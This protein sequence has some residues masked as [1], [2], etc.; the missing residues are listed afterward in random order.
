MIFLLLFLTP[1]L[2]IFLLAV[3]LPVALHPFN[4]SDQPDF[5]NIAEPSVDSIDTEILKERQT[6]SK[7][8]VV[9]QIQEAFWQARLG[10]A[11][12]D[13]I[14][15]SVDLIDSLINLE[16]KGVPMRLCKIQRYRSSGL[17]DRLR[18]QG[19]LRD[20]LSTPFILQKEL[21]TIP[22]API[23]IK[24][25]PKDTIEA[26]ESTGE[27]LKIEQHDVHFTLHF[28]RNLSISVAQ[29]QPSSFIGWLR[30]I[31]YD[32]RRLFGN[33]WE[34]LVALFQFNLPPHRIWI[35]LEISREDAKAIYRALPPSAGLALR[36]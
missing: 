12:R 20:W 34:A 28:D 32:S 21:A 23:H 24:E 9:L 25:A 29:L 5:E 26:N 27:E 13:S 7:K 18:R 16:I 1:P 30:K 33:A 31:F 19:R 36:L 11:K 17:T 22:K 15:L 2:L 10:L 4:E 6:L 14:N 3:L 35:E 8:I